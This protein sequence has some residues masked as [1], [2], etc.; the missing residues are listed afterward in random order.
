MKPSIL[1]GVALAFSAAVAVRAADPTPKEAVTAAAKKLG[2]KA[3]YSWK[4]T[5]VVPET[6]RWQ[7][8]PVEGKTEKDGVTHLRISF[9][10]NVTQAVMKG[11]K[12]AVTNPEGAWSSLAELENEEGPGRFWA[13]MLRGMATPAVQAAEMA[14]DTTDLKKEGEVYASALTEQG[15]KTLMSLR[16]RGAATGEG[17]AISDAKGSVRF[18]LKDG[19]LVKYEFKV[20]G[21]MSFGGNDMDVDRTT[22]VEIKD[23]GT[24]KIEVPEEAKKKLT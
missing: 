5:T 3:N 7:P 20:Q 11:E 13:G 15:A 21:K 12:G 6:A 1:I 17:P 18:W 4:T 9:M 22:T 24:T 2:E 8:G 14:A 19:E 23:V 10:D 16:R